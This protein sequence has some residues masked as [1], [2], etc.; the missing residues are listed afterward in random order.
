MCITAI[1]AGLAI[2]GT[3]MSMFGTYMTEQAESRIA[4]DQ[5]KAEI[6]MTKV[7]AAQETSDRLRIYSEMSATNRLAA[8][9]NLG[10]GTNLSFEQAIEPY[11]WGVMQEDL[12]RIQF[13]ADQQNMRRKYGIAVN[14]QRVRV[15]TIAAGVNT[16][17]QF[18]SQGS[19]AAINRMA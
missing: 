19:G 8:M 12:N 2:A 1:V 18:I 16:M 13:N 7:Q 15:N 6:A 17:G 5:L 11:N 9:V 4:N 14:K 3:G 10:G